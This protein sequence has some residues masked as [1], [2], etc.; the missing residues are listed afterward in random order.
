MLLKE[1]QFLNLITTSYGKLDI[2]E[3]EGVIFVHL[4]VWKW[5]PSKYRLMKHYWQV[6]LI[7]LRNRGIEDVFT[8]IS[9]DDIKAHKFQKMFGFKEQSRHNGTILFHRST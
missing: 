3:V 2:E 7:S 8:I 5:S 1:Q 4:E 9:S 6:A